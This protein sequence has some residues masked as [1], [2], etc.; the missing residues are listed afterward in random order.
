MKQFDITDGKII[1]ENIPNALVLM[2]RDF[3]GD[4]SKPFNYGG[5]NVILIAYTISENG[6]TLTFARV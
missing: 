4:W 6:G 1:F 5:Y 3:A 2:I